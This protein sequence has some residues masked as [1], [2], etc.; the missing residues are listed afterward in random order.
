MKV[1]VIIPTYNEKG[2]IER[3][4]ASL[5]EEVFPQIKNYE[6]NILVADDCSPDGTGRH[7]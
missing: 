7:S 5:E 6:M 2:N 3:L 1:V 4:S